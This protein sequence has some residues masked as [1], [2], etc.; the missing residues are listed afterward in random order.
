MSPTAKRHRARP[1]CRWV[2]GSLSVVAR[3]SAPLACHQIRPRRDRQEAP[4]SAVAPPTLLLTPYRRCWPRSPSV[5]SG[6]R[7]FVWQQ[8]APG[9]KGEVALSGEFDLQLNP[10]FSQRVL[11]AGAPLQAVGVS[12]RTADE[13]DSPMPKANQE[14]GQLSSR[15]PII[16][17]HSVHTRQWTCGRNCCCFHLG[18]HRTSD[19]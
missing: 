17:S 16:N 10:G 19:E 1:S 9:L 11:I 12:G 5:Y 18:K 6:D 15:R 4:A 3:T 7:E 8:R 13:P 14:C 2:V